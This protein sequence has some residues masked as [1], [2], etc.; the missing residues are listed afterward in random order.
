MFA[1][2]PGQPPPPSPPFPFPSLWWCGGGAG[3][4]DALSRVPAEDAAGCAGEF[5]QLLAGF[6]GEH[7]PG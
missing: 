7:V 3:D 4:P 5:V 6:E 1:G 2:V